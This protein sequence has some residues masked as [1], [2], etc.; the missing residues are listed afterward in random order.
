MVAA[1]HVLFFGLAGCHSGK[2]FHFFS[3]PYEAWLIQDSRRTMLPLHNGK[4]ESFLTTPYREL[5]WFWSA[6]VRY[7]IRGTAVSSCRFGDFTFVIKILSG[8]R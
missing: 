3:S 7:G 2:P 8:E 6:C 4:N 1:L 5:G